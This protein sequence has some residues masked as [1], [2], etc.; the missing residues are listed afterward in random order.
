MFDLL[1]EIYL[2]AENGINPAL[3]KISRI[4]MDIPFNFKVIY[5]HTLDRGADEEENF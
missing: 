3:L 4:A 5:E 2:L 1:N